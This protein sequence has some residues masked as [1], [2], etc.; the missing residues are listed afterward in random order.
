MVNGETERVHLDLDLDWSIS[1]SFSTP[2]TSSL[3][4]PQKKDRLPSLSGIPQNF[5]RS[6]GIPCLSSIPK[7]PQRSISRIPKSFPFYSLPTEN[8]SISSLNSIPKFP[9]NLPKDRFLESPQKNSLLLSPHRKSIN[10][11]FIQFPNQ[12]IPSH[13]STPQFPPTL[14][15]D[16][17]MESPKNS[18]LLFPHRKSINPPLFLSIPP[19]LPTNLPRT[20]QLSLSCGRVRGCSWREYGAMNRG[21][22]QGLKGK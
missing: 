20:P 2:K 3:V 17:S 1:P 21:K 14:P 22:I 7:F 9:S 8:Q 10:P 5:R 13:S 19:K 11:V 18:L 16:R 6:I 12:S 15:T 4:S